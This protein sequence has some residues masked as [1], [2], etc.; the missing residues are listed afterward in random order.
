MGKERWCGMYDQEL[1]DFERKAG[2]IDRH[3][4]LYRSDPDFKSIVDRT[5]YLT[6]DQRHAS[7]AVVGGLFGAT[8]YGT[9]HFSVWDS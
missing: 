7:E 3:S 4:D 8:G 9:G 2:F 1:R 6:A 5:I